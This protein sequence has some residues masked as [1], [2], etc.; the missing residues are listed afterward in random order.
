[1]KAAEI[2]QRRDQIARMFAEHSRVKVSRLTDLF[3]VSDET[4][5]KDLKYLEGQGILRTVYGGAVSDRSD[6]IEPVM[7]RTTTFLK[8][9][10]KIVKRALALIPEDRCII[11]LDQGSTVALLAHELNQYRNKV[12]MTRSLTSI[13]ELIH[14]TNEFYCIG[15]KYQPADMSFQGDAVGGLM[16]NIQLDIGFF[17][18]S[19]ILDRS[20]MCS[21]SLA[22]AEM[23]RTMLDQCRLKVVLIDHS[24][25]SRSSFVKV[26]DWEAID[27]VITDNEAPEDVLSQIGSMTNVVIAE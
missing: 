25:F 16:H 12:V 14:G 5:R 22:D 4:I 24:K 8:D 21:S 2:Q 26:A 3:H 19:G 13:L 1:M 10:Q 17:G 27:Y 15:G 11:G 9:K 23:K 20:G 18:S 6:F 7:Q